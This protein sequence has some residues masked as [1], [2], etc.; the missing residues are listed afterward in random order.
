MNTTEYFPSNFPLRPPLSETIMAGW[1]TRPGCFIP[2]QFGH[3]ELP[4]A[5]GLD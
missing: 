3:K 5:I 1:L 4:R 2:Y